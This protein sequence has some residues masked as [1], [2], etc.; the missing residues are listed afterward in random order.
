MNRKFKIIISIITIIALLAVGTFAWMNTMQNMINEFAGNPNNGGTLHD[1]FD[2]P[3]KDVY[4][5]NWGNSN[6][7]IR[8]KL[9]EYMEIGKGAGLKGTENNDGTWTANPDNKAVSEISGANIDDK[10]TWRTHI[11]AGSVEVCD[12]EPN[13]HNYWEWSMGGWKYYMPAPVDKRAD[14]V[15]DKWV[16]N[17]YVDQNNGIFNGSTE[18]VRKTLDSTGKVVTMQQWIQMGSPVGPYWVIDVDGWAYWASPLLPGE[19]TGLLLDAVNLVNT[20][21]DSYYYAINVMVQMAT[22]DGDESYKDFG[23]NSDS[24]HT[25]TNDGRDLLDKIVNYAPVVYGVNITTDNGTLIGDKIYLPQGAAANLTANVNASNNASTD[26]KWIQDNQ[27]GF[28]FT[29]Y[30]NASKVQ[31]DENAT[32]GSTLTV[33]ATSKANESKNDTKIIIIIDKNANGVVIGG[34]GKLYVD[35]GDNTFKEMNTDGTTKGELICGGM[36]EIPGTSDDRTDIIISGDGTKYLG[37]NPDDSYQKV[38]PDGSLGTEDD[39]YVWKINDSEAIS[40]DNETTTHPAVIQVRNIVI[41]PVTAEVMKGNS[42]QFTATVYMSDNSI[43]TAGVTWTIIPSGQATITSNGVLTVN[44]NATVND[45]VVIA[46]SKTNN[47]VTQSVTVTVK[48][49]IAETPT[50]VDGRILSAENAGDKSD[51]IEIAQNGGYSLLVRRDYI[52]VY[53]NGHYGDLAFQFCVYGTTNA[54]VSSNVRDA[55]NDWFNGDAVGDA[56]NLSSDAR[57]RNFTVLNNALNVIGTSNTASSLTNGFSKPTATKSSE[58]IDIAFALSFGE[59]ANFLSK[60]YAPTIS[61]GQSPSNDIAISNFNKINI[62]GGP[63][64]GVWLRSPGSSSYTAADV[65]KMGRVFQF[66]INNITNEWGFVYP[67]VWVE[68]TIFDN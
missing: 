19:A 41:N 36:D 35:Y 13:F 58:G 33:T 39:I 9:D 66:E 1:D 52:N 51:W 61:G 30:G 16:N 11:P 68:S 42:K 7:Y 59:A 12:S 32:I 48:P 6:L 20:P 54:Y 43:D 50:Q 4:V 45:L 25:W 15:D 31:A 65:D 47:T 38:G 24:D 53:Q 49:I 62:P 23:N 18:G 5:E 17:N 44:E 22:K 34:D 14:L 26:V 57:L 2:E 37:P 28:K 8:I 3:N 29:N 40:P 55:I 67:A 56:D 64:H 27:T 10:T 21:S 63:G 46:T 60:T